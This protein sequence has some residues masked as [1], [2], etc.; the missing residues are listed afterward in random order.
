MTVFYVLQDWKDYD[1]R[2]QGSGMDPRFFNCVENWEIDFLVKR[3]QHIYTLIPD[4]LIRTAITIACD[5]ET[6]AKERECFVSAVLAN[7]AIP[8]N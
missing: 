5:Q 2:K 7:L 6:V 1:I 3:I 8:A 4:A